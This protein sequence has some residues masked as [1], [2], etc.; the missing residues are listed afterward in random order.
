MLELLKLPGQKSVQYPVE[1]YEN[2]WNRELEV[3]HRELQG[4]V[5][6]PTV[7]EDAAMKAH[8]R[9]GFHIGVGFFNTDLGGLEEHWWST[10][11]SSRVV[12]LV[13]VQF[14]QKMF[15]WRKL[16]SCVLV[17]DPSSNL[18]RRYLRYSR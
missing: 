18:G 3:I 4:V 8:D 17:I 11:P 16:P 12:E 6:W 13:G 7:C 2:G 14:N 10:D 15:P 5:G 1:Y 9:L